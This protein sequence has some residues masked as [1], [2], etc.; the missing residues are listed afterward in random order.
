LGVRG[1]F[2][3]S[4]RAVAVAVRVESIQYIIEEKRQQTRQ[5]ELASLRGVQIPSPA[6][7]NGKSTD[8]GWIHKL[9]FFIGL[10]MSP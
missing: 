3:S 6:L 7:R 4:N 9:H 2:S 1:V 8:C 5:G 10:T